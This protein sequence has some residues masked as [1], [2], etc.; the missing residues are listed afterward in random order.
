MPILAKDDYKPSFLLRNGHVNSMYTFFRRKPLKPKFSR[1]TITTPDD[2]FLDLDTLIS[3]NSKCLF[4]CHGLEGST[5]SQYILGLSKWA[6][7]V[8]WDVIALNYR[9]CSGRVN[10]S[11]ISYHSGFTSDLNHVLH[12][13]KDNY[14]RISV[15]GFSLG[16][17]ILLKYLGENPDQLPD[18]LDKAVAIS[19]PVDPSSA[20]RQLK[21][22]SNKPYSR[23]FLNSLF[24]KIRQKHKLYPNDIDLSLIPKIKE[25]WDYDEYYTAQIHGFQGAEDYYA[26]C[27]S[28]QF[29]KDIS[30]DTLLINA[31]DD[32]FLPKECYPYDEAKD[33]KNLFFLACRYGGH[34]GFFSN[35]TKPFWHEKKILSFLL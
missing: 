25:I 9:G 8:G 10:K 21:K 5:D 11:L 28:K 26:K 35:K 1:Q 14:D 3:G 13:F 16:G 30:I 29:L 33:H 32:P 12:Y 18:N 22:L 20:S 4:L 31:L 6:S 24:G 2:D 27:N 7:E 17:N 23:N 15:V 19:T 34:V